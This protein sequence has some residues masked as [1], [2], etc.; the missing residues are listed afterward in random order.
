M[1]GL[2]EITKLNIESLVDPGALFKMHVKGYSMLPLL[3]F[4]DDVIVLRRTT[5]EDDIMGRIAMF[6][7]ADGHIIVH[8]VIDLRD[9]IVTLRGDGNI[10]QCERCRRKDIIGVVESVI[11]SNGKNVSCTTRSWQR[12]E[13]VWLRQ[14]QIVRRYALAIMRR[15]CNF[16]R[17]KRG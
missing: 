10:I 2:E 11:R 1:K 6:R 16:I 3:G 12:R 7:A 9:G 13:K 4:G 5:M 14:P 17:K 8:R 15:W